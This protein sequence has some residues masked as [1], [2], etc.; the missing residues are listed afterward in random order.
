MIKNLE[1]SRLIP[2][3]RQTVYN[4]IANFENYVNFIPG[5]SKAKLIEK[6]DDYEIGLL[7]FDF[8][9]RKYQ[10]K[11]KNI[12]SDFQIKIKQIEGPFDFFEGNWQIGYKS[13]DVSEAKLVTKFELPFLLANL[14]PDRVIDSFCESALEAFLKNLD[15]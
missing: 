6:N 11:S 5:C 1:V 15:N 8:L 12:L 3:D 9:L 7:E 4:E 10:I 2:K 14:V 13:N